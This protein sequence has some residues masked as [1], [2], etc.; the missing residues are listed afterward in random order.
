[1]NTDQI[2]LTCL[3]V[4]VGTTISYNLIRRWTRRT[5]RG[6]TTHNPEQ[7]TQ[8]ISKNLA[9]AFNI[10]TDIKVQIMILDKQET[11]EPQQITTNRMA[12]KEMENLQET[13]KDYIEYY[14]NSSTRV[15]DNR[16]IREK[17]DNYRQEQEANTQGT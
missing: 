14:G 7:L 4:S 16:Y 13:I 9:N 8:G 11:P 10:L 1:M 5:E 15:Q 3:A 12:I 17:L 2:L 6:Y